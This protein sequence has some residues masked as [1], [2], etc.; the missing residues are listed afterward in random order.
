VKQKYIGIPKRQN[1]NLNEINMI[2]FLIIEQDFGILGTC[3]KNSL[4]Y[5]FALKLKKI[6]SGF[7]LTPLVIL[8][9]QK[10]TN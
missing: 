2:K 8:I 9:F 5:P 1:L 6:V 4:T 3:Q 10:L 7:G